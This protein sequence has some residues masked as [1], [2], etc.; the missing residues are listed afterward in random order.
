MFFC[1]FKIHVL[2]ISLLNISSYLPFSYKL[3]SLFIFPEFFYLS[4]FFWFFEKNQKV[5]EIDDWRDYYIEFSKR[6]SR[7]RSVFLNFEW[8]GLKNVFLGKIG[9]F[10]ASQPANLVGGFFD[11]GEEGKARRERK[12]ICRS[13]HPLGKLRVLAWGPGCWRT[14][15]GHPLVASLNFPAGSSWVLFPFLLLFLFS[16][17]FS[18]LFLPSS[19]SFFF[20]SLC[21]PSYLLLFNIFMIVTSG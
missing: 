10:R 3:V 6:N 17:L 1:L 15:S 2:H 18:F 11:E 21:F 5:S 13:N 12:W 19:L 14:W 7:K 16:F 8:K 9:I 4:N 20:S